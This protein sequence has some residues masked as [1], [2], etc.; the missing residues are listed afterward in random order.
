MLG[1]VDSGDEASSAFLGSSWTRDF[2]LPVW[3][4]VV[5]FPLTSWM[6]ILLRGFWEEEEEEA[7]GFAFILHSDAVKKQEITKSLIMRGVI[8]NLLLIGDDLAFLLAA[9][10]VS[11]SRQF[12]E[13]HWRRHPTPEQQGIKKHTTHNNYNALK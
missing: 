13:D 7:V 10:F 11:V 9:L 4:S 1:D 3:F 2:N 8:G 12:A 6:L 5:T